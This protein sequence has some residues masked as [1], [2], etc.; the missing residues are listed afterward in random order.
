[1]KPL[2]ALPPEQ[3]HPD[4][5]PEINH[6]GNLLLV[7]DVAGKADR[8]AALAVNTGGLVRGKLAVEICQNDRSPVF[9]KHASGCETHAFVRAGHQ[10]ELA[11]KIVNRVH[12]I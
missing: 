11:V 9:G 4:C 2:L 1:M 7:G 10:G 8:S 5:A 12:V 3:H 6:R